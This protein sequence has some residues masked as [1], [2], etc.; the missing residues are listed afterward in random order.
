MSPK[1]TKRFYEEVEPLIVGPEEHGIK[2][3]D[4]DQDALQVMRRLR[5]AGHT[6]YLVGGGVRDL[7]L[8]KSPKDYD[9]STDARPGQ[10]RKIFRNSRTIG[11]RFRLVQVFFFGQ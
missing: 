11:R 9:I 7:F 4:F 6:A 5:E 2:L 3:A 8:G 10:L 1:K